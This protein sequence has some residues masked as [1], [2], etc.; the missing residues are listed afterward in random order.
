VQTRYRRI[1]GQNVVRFRGVR[2]LTQKNLADATRLSVDWISLI[3]QGRVNPTLDVIV[4]L[5][6]ALKLRPADLLAPAPDSRS[7]S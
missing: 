3:E 4:D 7:R 2:G 6:L 5:A 1:L